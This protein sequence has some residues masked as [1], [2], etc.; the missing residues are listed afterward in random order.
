MLRPLLLSVGISDKH[1]IPVITVRSGGR[2][3]SYRYPCALTVVCEHNL[4]LRPDNTVSAFCTVNILH[5]AVPHDNPVCLL[6][7]H[8]VSGLQHQI[9]VIH[10]NDR[11]R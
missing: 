9:I 2:I 1:D 8:D 7:I 11:L 5:S 4:R 3:D 10:C 6:I